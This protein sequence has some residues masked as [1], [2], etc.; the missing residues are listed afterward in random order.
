MISYYFLLT[1]PQTKVHFLVEKIPPRTSLID[2]SQKKRAFEE[3]ETIHFTWS[4]LWHFCWGWKKNPDVKLPTFGK[5]YKNFVFL[6]LQ[7]GITVNSNGVTSSNHQNT[8]TTQQT[9]RLVWP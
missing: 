8:S 4:F 6:M 1:S 5:S 7:S 9:K 2:D 3:N